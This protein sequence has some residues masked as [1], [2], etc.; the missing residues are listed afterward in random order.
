[1]PS[2]A[3]SWVRTA[4]PVEHNQWPDALFV[5][6]GH[7]PCPQCRRRSV[8]V[9]DLAARKVLRRIHHGLQRPSAVVVGQCTPRQIR[10]PLGGFRL[11]EKV[12][13]ATAAT[14]SLLNELVPKNLT[15]WR[16]GECR[17]E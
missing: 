3:R 9:G 7:P 1:M 15:V 4:M 5:P 14:P 10:K 8:A 6:P 11:V 13:P 2:Y 17:I 12:L 16:W